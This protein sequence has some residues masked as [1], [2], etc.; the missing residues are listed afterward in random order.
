MFEQKSIN[1]FSFVWIKTWCKKLSFSLFNLSKYNI[2]L[3][4]TKK[5]QP[6]T[7]SPTV[8]NNSPQ[9]GWRNI[10]NYPLVQALISVQARSRDDLS[11][12]FIDVVISVSL[13]SL[14]E[15][16]RRRRRRGTSPKRDDFSHSGHQVVWKR[17]ED[18]EAGVA[19]EIRLAACGE[20]ARGCGWPCG[21][22]SC[23]VQ[24]SWQHPSAPHGP[25]SESA[26]SHSR[27]SKHAG[28]VPPLHGGGRL[29]P[30]FFF[31]VP[32]LLPAWNPVDQLS[33]TINRINPFP[34]PSGS[35]S[36]NFFLVP[37]DEINPGR[38]FVAAK[39]IRNCNTSVE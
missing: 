31:V 37:G 23:A 20:R 35:G 12:I 22:R 16:C 8:E 25:P 4:T 10:E 30:Q 24:P 33:V 6:I 26:A 17:K 9:S 29:C 7:Y 13:S 18:E 19:P 38:R 5:I 11:Q 15:D 3:S 39:F 2:P 27:G 14:S 32:R 28:S 34:P 1:W 36:R 21:G